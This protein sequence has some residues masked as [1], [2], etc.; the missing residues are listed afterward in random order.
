MNKLCITTGIAIIMVF[1]LFVSVIAQ[2][3][4]QLKIP[5]T[6]PGQPGKLKVDINSGSITVRGS[7]VSEVI[8]NYKKLERKIK[9]KNKGESTNKDGLTKISA[10]ALDLEAYEKNNTVVVES[11]SWGQGVDLDIQVPKNFDLRLEGYNNGDIQVNDI[12]GEIEAVNYNG[13]IT[14]ENISGSVVAE[15]YNGAIVVT[16]DKVTPDTPMA[17]INYNGRIDLSFP[18]STKASFKLKSKQGEIYE[19]FGMEMIQSKVKT[20]SER[21]KSGVYKVK[22]D[23][24]VRG[25]INGG[26]PEITIQ[27]YNGNIYIRKGN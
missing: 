8:I 15:T 9:D 18:A 24:W 10:N 25:N 4:G 16:F 1:L 12:V 14:L 7:N 17:Y 11:D 2:D 23:T 26:G 3:S 22:V 27:T 13:K 19:G 21:T 6:N 20:E 5:L